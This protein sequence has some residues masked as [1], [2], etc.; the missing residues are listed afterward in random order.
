LR[1]EQ[2]FTILWFLWGFSI[3]RQCSGVGGKQHGRQSLDRQ[4]LEKRY[5]VLRRRAVPLQ[6][7]LLSG[8]LRLFLSKA[9]ETASLAAGEELNPA[10]YEPFYDSA[11]GPMRP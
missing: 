9:P 4:K 11:C 2:S 6:S 8:G 10:L 1:V 5:S 7:C 3:E